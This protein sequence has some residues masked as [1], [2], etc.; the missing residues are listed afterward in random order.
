MRVLRVPLLKTIVPCR[1]PWFAGKSL[2]QRLTPKRQSESIS[3][4]EIKGIPAVEKSRL[5]RHTFVGIDLD[6]SRDQKEAGNSN[7]DSATYDLMQQRREGDDM[8]LEQRLETVQNGIA[9]KLTHADEK[10]R[11]RMVDTSAKPVTYRQASAKATVDVG[12]QIMALLQENRI[13]K[14]DVLCVAEVAGVLGAKKTQALIPLCHNIPLTDVQVV[15][16]LDHSQN[17]VHLESV[18]RCAANTGAE[19]EALTAVSIAALTVYDMCKAVSKRIVIRE[20]YLV[21][22]SGGKSGDYSVLSEQTPS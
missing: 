22:K 11:A 17:V 13:Q 15:A 20:I 2:S 7:S 21:T 9:Q 14:G 1:G 6:E 5:E 16:R 10:G 3:S 8:G 4:A 18:V 12:P 19:M